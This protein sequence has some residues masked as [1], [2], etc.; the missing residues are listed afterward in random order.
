MVA[1]GFAKQLM[2]TPLPHPHLQSFSSDL[3]ELRKW[4]WAARGSGCSICSILATQLTMGGILIITG[5]IIFIVNC[6]ILQL[7]AM[8][9]DTTK[10]TERSQHS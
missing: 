1:T 3:L 8:M 7:I 2:H 10:L 9:N 4:S 6:I 5:N